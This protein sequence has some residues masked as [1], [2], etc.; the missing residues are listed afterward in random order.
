MPQSCGW[1]SSPWWLPFISA[2]CI[3][4]SLAEIGTLLLIALRVRVCLLRARRSIVLCDSGE[5]VAEACELGIAHPPGYPLFTLLGHAATW[6]NTGSP[7]WRV[8]AMNAGETA[9]CYCVVLPTLLTVATA[10]AAATVL[11][12][13]AAVLLF[14]I[15][16]SITHGTRHHSA[17]AAAC[18]AVRESYLAAASWRTTYSVHTAGRCCLP[19]RR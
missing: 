13:L 1:A 12:T 15:V 14:E 7:A 17:E 18:A 4:A 5:L 2:R 3:P 8:N 19:F 11:A 6:I 10:A 9:V 16:V